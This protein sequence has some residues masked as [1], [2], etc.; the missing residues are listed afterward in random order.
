MNARLVLAD[1]P[2]AWVDVEFRGRTYRARMDP[3]WLGAERLVELIDRPPLVRHLLDEQDRA[4]VLTA[5]PFGRHTVGLLTSYVDAVGLGFKG[6][7]NL[8]HGL[9]HLDLLEVDLL[10][11]GLDVRDWLDPE[12]PLSSRRVALLIADFLYRPE[13]QLGADAFDIRPASKT[14]VVA[15]QMSKAHVSDENYVHPFLKSPAEL[16]AEAKARREAEEKRERIRQQRFSTVERVAPGRESF[17]SAQARS[18][19]ALAEIL[20]SQG[21]GD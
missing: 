14:A 20:A 12:G 19:Q 9:E 15:A 18:R 5:D 7:V 6:L 8:R 17:K 1:E 21:G 10:R 16:E 4:R 11:I 13:T 2:G 3:M